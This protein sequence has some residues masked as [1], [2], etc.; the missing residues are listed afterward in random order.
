MHVPLM[1]IPM[2]AGDQSLWHH[3]KAAERTIAEEEEGHGSGP[4]MEAHDAMG[5]RAC[6]GMAAHDQK[7]QWIMRSGQARTNLLAQNGSR[8]LA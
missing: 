6:R 5:K 7:I 2:G 8:H 1:A 3:G 4:A